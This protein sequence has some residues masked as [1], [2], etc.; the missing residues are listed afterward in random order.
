[1]QYINYIILQHLITRQTNMTEEACSTYY[2]STDNS[3]S[4]MC[5]SGSDVRKKKKL[6]LVKTN[7]FYISLQKSP[8]FTHGDWFRVCFRDGKIQLLNSCSVIYLKNLMLRC[9][10]EEILVNPA[11]TQLLMI[12]YYSRLN[13]GFGLENTNYQS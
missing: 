3:I 1:M 5:G 10:S 13:Y 11:R 12:S 2:I 6:R 7:F 8:T 9:I 4:F